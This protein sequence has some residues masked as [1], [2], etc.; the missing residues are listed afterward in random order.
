V[1]DNR[2]LY[3]IPKYEIENFS[4]YEQIEKCLQYNGLSSI[5]LIH[6][7]RIENEFRP[8]EFSFIPDL[9]L[10]IIDLDYYVKKLEPLPKFKKKE[11]LNN[12]KNDILTFNKFIFKKKDQIA[13]RELNEKKKSIF[14]LDFHDFTK[15]KKKL[16]FHSKDNISSFNDGI[17]YF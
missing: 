14:H 8:N 6:K 2:E 1:C 16:S 10:F 11:I 4:E 3:N 12:F 5:F 17:F 15:S 7:E 9:F 13:N